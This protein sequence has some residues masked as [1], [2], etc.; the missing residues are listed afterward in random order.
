M[1]ICDNSRKQQSS[2]YLQS[3]GRSDRELVVIHDGVIFS[4]GPSQVHRNTEAVVRLW[5]GKCHHH[6]PNSCYWVDMRW[7]TLLLESVKRQAIQQVAKW[8]N[9]RSILHH[10][11]SRPQ[12]KANRQGT[13]LLNGWFSFLCCCNSH[14]GS[15]NNIKCTNILLIT[16]ILHHTIAIRRTT[17]N[18]LITLVML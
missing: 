9:W 10:W 4:N 1:E 14:F 12:T 6:S 16:Y 2:C 13:Q 11:N 15:S 5:R 7:V 8:C 17:N 18:T 3:A